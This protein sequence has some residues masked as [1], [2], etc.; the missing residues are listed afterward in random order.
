MAINKTFGLSAASDFVPPT[1]AATKTAA[2]IIMRTIMLNLFGRLLLRKS[3]DL[4]R[5]FRGAKRDTHPSLLKLRNTGNAADLVS[6]N[7]FR[8]LCNNVRMFVGHVSFL[9]R[10]TTE[11]EQ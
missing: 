5:F 9:G 1:D 8:N 7:R 11:V 10:V 4:K 2:S 6:L 3:D